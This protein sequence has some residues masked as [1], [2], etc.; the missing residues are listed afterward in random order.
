MNPL[1]DW[2]FMMAVFGGVALGI[3]MIF[4]MLVTLL[5]RLAS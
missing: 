2:I 4:A 1:D 5:M 3:A